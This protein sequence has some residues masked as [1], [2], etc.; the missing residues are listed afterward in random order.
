MRVKS[1]HINNLANW[2]PSLTWGMLT[3]EP[4]ENS[5]RSICSSVLPFD[6]NSANPLK[7]IDNIQMVVTFPAPNVASM[8]CLFNPDLIDITNGCKFTAKIKEARPKIPEGVKTTSP[9]DLPKT[10]ENAINKTLAP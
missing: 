2:D 8:E 5:P 6:G 4:T 9:D 3:I 10:D 1:S 7:P